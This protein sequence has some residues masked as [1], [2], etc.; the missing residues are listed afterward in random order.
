MELIKAEFEVVK[1]KVS[2]LLKLT[3]IRFGESDKFL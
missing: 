2:D 3:K 1:V